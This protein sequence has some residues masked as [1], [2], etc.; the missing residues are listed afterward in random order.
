MGESGTIA[1]AHIGWLRRCGHNQKW[2]LSDEVAPKGPSETTL[3]RVA[4]RIY[5]NAKKERLGGKTVSALLRDRK[6]FPRILIRQFVWRLE[7]VR[8]RQHE[9]PSSGLQTKKWPPQKGRP[10]L[11]RETVLANY[12]FRKRRA[13]PRA[14]RAAPRSITVV[15][16]SGV[17]TPPGQQNTSMWESAPVKG[18][19]KV[20]VPL[21]P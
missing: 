20:K 16:P 3:P 19:S 1:I 10:L 2:L 15:P 6:Q 4:I 5:N 7:T 14:P 13:I 9:L 18:T 12:L 17:V 21:D 11:C 8:G